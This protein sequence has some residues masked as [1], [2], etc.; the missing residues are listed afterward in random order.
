MGGN[1]D[2]IKQRLDIVEVISSYV[3][4]EKGGTNYK[5]RCPFHNEKT[6]S[7]YV[8]PSRQSYYC[9]GC[10]AKGDMFSFVE[11]IEGLDFRGA[12]KILADRAGV[13]LKY[14]RPAQKTEK[15]AL[16]NAIQEAANFFQNNLEAS[17]EAK[18]YLKKRG[19]KEETIKEWNIGFAPDEWRL[20]HSHLT[21][22]NYKEELLIKAGLV[23]RPDEAKEKNPYDIFR[24]RIIFPIRDSVG[25]II[26]FS[27]RALLAKTEPKYLNTPDTVLFKKSDVL[28]GLD[29]AK[30]DIRKK[31]YT[32]L[33]EGYTDLLLSVQSGVK[34]IVAACG[35]AFTTQHLERLRRLS[36]RIILAYDGDA[37]G[38]AAAFKSAVVALANGL[39]VKI[40]KMPEGLDPAETIEKDPVLWKE[41]LRESK[42]AIEYFL[43]KII[44]E[45]KDSRK[46]GKLIETKILPLIALLGSSIE[47][48]HYVS[49]LSKHTGLR[50]EVIWEDLRKV[51]LPDNLA[52]EPEKGR[53]E[54]EAAKAPRKTNI[55]RRLVG[56]VYWQEGLE[57]PAVDVSGLKNE[58]VSRTGEEYFK[59]LYE[60][61][62][63]ERENLI[64]E[65][66]SYY[67][68]VENLS[69]D[70]TELLDNLSDDILR[71]NLSKTT[72]DLALAE[73]SK[74]S[75]TIQTLTKEIQ[76]IIRAKQALEEKRKT[77]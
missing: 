6:P 38:E 1:V 47:R 77:L 16:E 60:S 18:E 4:L 44:K 23:K 57:M 9:F 2:R 51:K 15:E 48:S 7:F 70:I 27:G 71:E 46:R 69:K 62:G 39:E 42:H 14:E 72:R 63:I 76:G 53:E 3:K 31:D 19:I 58:M 41:S 68:E 36:K 25:K 17:P 10:G 21:S 59:S 61:L 75:R 8:S 32:I 45:E 55:E 67:A 33:V 65:A 20:L 54:I 13:E 5:A 73:A 74:D 24:G 37:A 50:D 28:Y 52:F 66:E 49:M 12:L 11:E 34:N 64:F 30:E 22:L 26:A 56:I 35:T 40:A 29:K 43:L